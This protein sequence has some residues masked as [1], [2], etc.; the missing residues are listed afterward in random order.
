MGMQL[1]LEVQ[2]STI[3]DEIG[4]LTTGEVA[5]YIPA[6]QA[7][8]PDW[9]SISVVTVNSHRY[10]IGDCEQPFTIQSVSKPFAFAMALEEHGI[11]AVLRRVGVEPSGDPFNSIELDMTTHRPYNPMVNAGAILTTSLLGAEDTV[12]T[13]FARFAG[14]ALPVDQEVWRSESDNGDRNRA[15][16][17]LM[18]SFGMLEGDVETTLQA[19]FRQCSRLV[20][21]RDLATM[22]AT[23]AN[24]GVNPITGERA[25]SEVNV[26]RVLSVMSTCGMYDYAGEWLYSVGLPAK[27]GVS[28]AVLAV[29][30][31][32]FGLAVFSP[33]LDEHGN[34]V[35]GI[36]FCEAIS[37]RFNLH[38]FSP[39][40]VDTS[41]VRRTYGGDAVR[42]KRQ[43][44]AFQDAALKSLGTTTKVFE[45]QGQLHFGSCEVLSRAIAAEL[46]RTELILLDFRRVSTVDR[47]VSTLLRAIAAM[48]EDSHAELVIAGAPP[49]ITQELSALSFGALDDALEWREDQLLERG[50]LEHGSGRIPLADVE[51][52]DGVDAAFIPRIEAI[53]RFRCYD[54]GEL[55]VNE[56]DPADRIYFVVAGRVDIVLG[57]GRSFLR[58]TTFG[59]GAAFG[60]MAA[61]YGGTRTAGV[62]AAMPSVCFE[63]EV[64]ALNELSSDRPEVLLQVHTNIARSLANRVRQLSDEVR[65]LS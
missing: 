35:R 29:L 33:R 39:L 50:N 47:S 36:A 6:L 52:F 11:D 57:V 31:G 28:G 24:R 25:V 38:L 49:E 26:S 40:A 3:F 64:A 46:D 59:P 22:G 12:D 63:L 51:L 18:H 45:L 60:E 42:S 32:Q 48:V 61:L 7:A 37:E 20:D 13:G 65:A 53:G 55:V 21:T 2:L 17:Y 15:I 19:Y 16:A 62:R 8:N 10:D 41:V 27:S 56:G 43:R 34:S 4:R 54:E 9:F 23:L 44:L 5:D 30:P 1:P 14:H 58:M